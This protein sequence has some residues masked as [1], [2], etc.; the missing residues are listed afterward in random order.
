MKTEWEWPGCRTTW[1]ARN[2]SECGWW[3]VVG[4]H[5]GQATGVGC[6]AGNLYRFLT[7]IMPFVKLS[8]YLEYHLLSGMLARCAWR[9]RSAQ[10]EQ[11]EAWRAAERD[12]HAVT[13]QLAW[14]RHRQRRRT[15]GACSIQAGR[16]SG[17]HAAVMYGFCTRL[18]CGLVNK[19]TAI[20]FT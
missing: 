5:Q 4:S 3:L 12:R 11:L 18:A 20:R 19:F 15:S 6:P 1:S 8:T 17:V 9:L 10:L 13:V 14:R 16:W 2:W 7:R